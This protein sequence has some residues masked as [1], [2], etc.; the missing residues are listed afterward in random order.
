M[1]SLPTLLSLTKLE[2]WTC[3]I[4]MMNERIK[5][6][7]FFSKLKSKYVKNHEADLLIIMNCLQNSW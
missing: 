6:R 2:Q 7:E 3:I 5:E 4:N 1:Y